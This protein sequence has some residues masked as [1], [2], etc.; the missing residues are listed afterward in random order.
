MRI[1]PGKF[2]HGGGFKNTES[3][4]NYRIQLLIMDEGI[5]RCGAIKYH[6]E[7]LSFKN[8]TEK[9][10]AIYNFGENIDNNNNDRNVINYTYTSIKA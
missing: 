9:E 2:I 4:G 5:K 10:L 3:T 6:N 8:V 7:H 1:L